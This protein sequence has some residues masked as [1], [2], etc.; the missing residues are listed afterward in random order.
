M[1]LDRGNVGL[2]FANLHLKA[3]QSTLNACDEHSVTRTQDFLSRTL[4]VHPTARA[5]DLKVACKLI[6][7]LNYA[8]WLP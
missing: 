8:T 3:P 5:A 6:N 2:H 7:T 1:N 4:S